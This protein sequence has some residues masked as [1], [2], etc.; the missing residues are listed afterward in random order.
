MIQDHELTQLSNVEGGVIAS[1]GFVGIGAAIGLVGPFLAALDK[2]GLKHPLPLS[3]AERFYLVG[4]SGTVVLG[5]V[6]LVIHGLA[7]WRKKGLADAIRKRPKLG[8][9]RGA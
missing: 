7:S 6:C 8:M 5:I 2:I 1:L 9:S 4:F 3:A